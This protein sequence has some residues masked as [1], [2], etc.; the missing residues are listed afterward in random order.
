MDSSAEKL[1]SLAKSV[2]LPTF[3]QVTALLSTGFPST[4]HLISTGLPG[5]IGEVVKSV[6]DIMEA[7]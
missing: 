1:V 6:T 5:F 7:G 4:L 3:S 2:L